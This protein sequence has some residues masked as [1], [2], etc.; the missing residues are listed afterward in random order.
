MEPKIQFNTL[1][2]FTEFF[3]GERKDGIW[4]VINFCHIAGHNFPTTE[5]V[6][7]SRQDPEL[8]EPSQLGAI[9]VIPRDSFFELT[10]EVN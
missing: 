1:V 8:F 2:R 10:T 5:A 7:L 3:G 9:L 6:M 4:R